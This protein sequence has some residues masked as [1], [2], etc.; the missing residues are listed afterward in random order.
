MQH[1]FEINVSKNGKHYFA[2][3]ERSLTGFAKEAI[4]MANDFEKR[5]PSSEGFSIRLTEWECY[6]T[7]I[8]HKNPGEK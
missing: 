2:T 5:F 1:H 6:G 7:G 3:H 8:D 4:A